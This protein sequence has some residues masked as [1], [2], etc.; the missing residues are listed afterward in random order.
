[1]AIFRDY[2]INPTEHDRTIGD[3]RR[4]RELVEKA[5]KDNL[6]DIVS[7]ESI[8]GESKSKKIKIPIRGLKEYKF[9]YGNNSS[10]VG[11][12]TGNEKKGDIIGKEQ[13]GNGS[14]GKGKGAGNSEGEDIYETEVT[15][16]EVFSYLLEDL[17]LPNL[18]KKK[19][20]EIVTDSSKKKAGYQ[21]YGIRPRLAKKRTVIEKIKREQSRKRAIKELGKDDKV[22]RLPFSEEDLRYHRI[23]EKPKKECNAAIMCVM[24]CSGSMDSTKKYLARSFFFILSKFIR[25]KYVNVEIAFISH[26]TVGREVTETEFFHKVES[27]GTYISSGLNTAMDIIKERFNPATWNIYGFYVSDGDNFTEDDER[28][29]KSM[30]KFCEIANMIGYAEILPYSYSGT[31]KYKFDNYVKDKNFISS[32]IRNKEDLWPVLKKMLIKELKE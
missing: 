26:S 10:S 23:K 14:K 8:I 11:S 13:M 24:D 12:G 27:G 6:A 15:I 20:S 5:I 9:L 3:R 16:E 32:T 22:E 31:M 25:M 29:I 7:E 2:S 28:A 4:H 17:N 1:M 19:Y 21:K 30:R 18:D